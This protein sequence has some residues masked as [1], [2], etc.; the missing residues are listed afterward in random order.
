MD[1][2]YKV[3]E[4]QSLWD[5]EL[6]YSSYA[7]Y[8]ESHLYFYAK[9]ENEVWNL[10]CRYIQDVYD[11]SEKKWR[12]VEMIILRPHNYEADHEIYICNN[13]IYDEDIAHRIE[14]KRLKV[15]HFT[16]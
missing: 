1:K 2:D 10:L 14:I 6:G 4:K 5:V 11:N 12:E 9:S 7:D 8:V 15:I 13:K 16:K 3:E